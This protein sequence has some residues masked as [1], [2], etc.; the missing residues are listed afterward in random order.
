MMSRMLKTLSVLILLVTS[1]RISAAQ[2]TPSTILQSLPVEVQR[3]VEEVRASCR[4]YLKD[5]DA[6]RAEIPSGDDALERFTLSGALAVMVSDLKLCG[7]CYKSANCHTG[8]YEMA[9]YVRSGRTWRKAHE[10]G[11][12]SGGIFLSLDWNRDPPAFRAMV[13]GIPG[14]SRDCPQ[15]DAFVR[16][17]GPTAWKRS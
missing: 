1:A 13:V 9:I 2:T 5:I 11:V 6:G 3:H 4:E 8:G 12:R 14:D 17:Y 15:R 7:E 16:A 10:D